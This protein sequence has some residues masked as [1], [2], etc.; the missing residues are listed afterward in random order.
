MPN[1][2]YYLHRDGRTYPFR[3]CNAAP[4]LVTETI[5]SAEYDK[6]WTDDGI[7][8]AKAGDYTF[9]NPAAT[10][11]LNTQ[12]SKVELAAQKGVTLIPSGT[13][14]LEK[15][16]T[17]TVDGSGS[18]T[19]HTGIFASAADFK[20]A[21]SDHKN[22]DQPLR[23]DDIE[24]TMWSIPTEKTPGT[25]KTLKFQYLPGDI[26]SNAPELGMDDD[27]PDA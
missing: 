10:S 7:V 15:L 19:T 6:V 4:T 9:T 5:K 17:V 3:Y 1:E 11:F 24:V 26:M 8:T 18:N 13:V 12:K 25:T 20:V 23:V 22:P 21:V 2:T 16:G 27:T 14:T